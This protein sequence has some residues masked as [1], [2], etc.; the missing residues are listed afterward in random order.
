MVRKS[1][2]KNWLSKYQ[3]AGPVVKIQTPMP[4][5]VLFDGKKFLQW[6][7]DHPNCLMV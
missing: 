3:Q 2:N 7:K 5:D 6:M 1:L 4:A